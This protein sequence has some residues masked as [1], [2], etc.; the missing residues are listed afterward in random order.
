A[1]EYDAGFG[2]DMIRLAAS[3]V[4]EVDPVQVG[5]FETGDG[6]ADLDRLYD[7]MSNRLGPLAVPRTKF[8]NSRIPAPAARLEPVIARTAAGDAQAAPDPR[9][10]RPLRLLPAPEAITVTA[11][12]PDGPPAG[13]VWRRIGYRFHKASGPERIAVE[14]WRP[15]EGAL[16]RDYFVAEDDGGR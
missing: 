5:A 8:V 14:W 9:L 3:S 13:M 12:V 10:P 6:A 16:T 4:S 7:R 1:G 11:E 15:G 2:I